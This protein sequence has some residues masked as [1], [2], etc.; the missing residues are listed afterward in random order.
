MEPQ[1]IPCTPCPRDCADD[2]NHTTV[3]VIGTIPLSDNLGL[4]LTS[5]CCRVARGRRHI[6][7]H[8]MPGAGG[9]IVFECE[10]IRFEQWFFIYFFLETPVEVAQNMESKHVASDVFSKKLS[11][12]A[13]LF[14]EYHEGPAKGS[15]FI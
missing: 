4:D 3:G 10:I 14:S 6:Y 8:N 15:A 5:L 2:P 12:K 7:I 1:F 11:V 13:G 9:G